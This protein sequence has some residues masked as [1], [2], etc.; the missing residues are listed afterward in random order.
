MASLWT[1]S[2]VLPLTAVDF[3]AKRILLAIGSLQ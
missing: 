2:Y 1:Q 3:N